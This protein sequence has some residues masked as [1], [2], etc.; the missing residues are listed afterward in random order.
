MLL[1]TLN[2][3]KQVAKGNLKW[4]DE[5]IHIRE[6]LIV[7]YFKLLA[8]QT[9][10][11]KSVDSLGH[12]EKSELCNFCNILI[13]YL[14]KGHFEVYPKILTIMENVSNRRLTIARRLIPRIEKTTEPLVVFS[15]RYAEIKGNLNIA[16]LRK[17]LGNVGQLLEV[18][19]KHEDRMVIALQILD[20]TVAHANEILPE[21]QSE[22]DDM[23][24]RRKYKRV[25]YQSKGQLIG[26]KFDVGVTVIDVS[27]KG[28]LVKTNTPIEAEIKTAGILTIQVAE[29][30]HVFMKVKIARINGC[31]IGLYCTE[32]DIESITH[33]RKLLEL[34]CDNPS[35]LERD[36][37]EL[38]R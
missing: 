11:N 28:A 26:A 19:F 23:H 3:T 29:D 20:N 12:P 33:L 17:D 4:I 6:T 9:D 38:I 2:R 7:V 34:N 30:V 24:E 31:D 16:K 14:S 8:I 36:L 27:I 13:D 25:A 22:D 10:P 32:I 18:R 5:M 37:E 35:L 21:T 1:T 15:D